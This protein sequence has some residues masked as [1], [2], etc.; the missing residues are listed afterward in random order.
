[1]STLIHAI[2]K[3]NKK[4][5]RVY[6]SWGERQF[7]K[8]KSKE[9]L[10][11]YLTK[12]LNLPESTSKRDIVF[13]LM[14]KSWD[15]SKWIDDFRVKLKSI[16]ESKNLTQAQLASMAGLSLEGIRALEQ[17]LRL[18]S[19]DTVRRIA[20]VLSVGVDKL[21]QIP[22]IDPITETHNVLNS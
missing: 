20:F 10:Y 7:P 17:G 16:R 15:G 11:S 18:P 2:K 12:E 4:I 19:A 5:Y 22:K 1:M 14:N 3:N 13:I 9:E 21:L 8:I 6:G